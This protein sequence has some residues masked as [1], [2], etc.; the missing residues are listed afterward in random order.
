MT[1]RSGSDGGSALG[2]TLSRG[3]VDDRRDGRLLPE[4]LMHK[5]CFLISVSTLGSLATVCRA[6]AA[7]SRRARLFRHVECKVPRFFKHHG[8]RRLWTWMRSAPDEETRSERLEIAKL[9]VLDIDAVRG[10]AHPMY[11]L[12]HKAVDEEDVNLIKAI[13]MLG[14]DVNRPNN[15]GTTPRGRLQLSLANLFEEY[16]EGVFLNNA[17]G[18]ACYRAKR[19]HLLHCMRALS[20]THNCS[21]CE[22]VRF[23]RI[24]DGDLQDM[25]PNL[26]GINR[27]TV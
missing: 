15:L 1:K 11:P 3:R 23:G 26:P 13:V 2:V 25:F 5:L 24:T 12:L 14:A 21:E 9:A 6:Y 16:A 19:E 20:E 18:R 4:G 10:I 17:E 8:L 27:W 22:P 7:S